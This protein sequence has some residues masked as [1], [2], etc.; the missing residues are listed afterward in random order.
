MDPKRAAL[1]QRLAAQDRR[2]VFHYAMAVS[3]ARSR[4][5]EGPSS[6]EWDTMWVEIQKTLGVWP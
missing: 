3:R 5:E 6:S 2:E 1:Y 4:G